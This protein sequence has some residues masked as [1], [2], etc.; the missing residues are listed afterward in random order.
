[1]P[2]FNPHN[3]EAAF[4][5][6]LL[7]QLERDERA[8]GVAYEPET[9]ELPPDRPELFPA[10]CTPDIRWRIGIIRRMRLASKLELGLADIPSVIYLELCSAD[11]H[12]SPLSMS[13]RSLNK[14]SQ[15]SRSGK[16]WVTPEQYLEYK[17]ER[18]EAARRRYGIVIVLLCWADQ[19]AIFACPERL[20]ELMLAELQ[21]RL[22]VPSTAVAV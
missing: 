9:F 7:K 22:P 20:E 1:M 21:R 3:G 11:R 13:A 19:Q 15:F 2:R 16:S 18:L 14:N 8:R 4:F 6:F 5:S 10:G 17:Q 12:P